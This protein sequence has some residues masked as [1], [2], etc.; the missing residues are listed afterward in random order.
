MAQTDII[1]ILQWWFMLFCGGLTVLPIMSLIFPSFVD[2][3]Y[4]FAKI[5]GVVLIS[6]LVFVFGTIRIAPFTPLTIYAIAVSVT[7]IS[8]IVSSRTRSFK[9]LEF[10]QRWMIFL[11]EEVLFLAALWFWAYVRSFNPDIYGLEKYMDFGF[12]NSILRTAYFPPRDMWFTP[13]SINYYYFGHLITAV[14]TKASQI[15]SYITFNLM[16]ATIFSFCFSQIYSL[17]ATLWRHAFPQN[18]TDT[19]S[20]KKKFPGAKSIVSTG[21]LAGALVSL[22]GNLHV[23]YALFSPYSNDKPQPLWELKFLPATFPNSYWYP[24]ATRFIFN[25]IHEFPIYS[26]VVSD[27]HGHVLDIP[28]VLLTISL[29]YS[30]FVRNKNL[31]LKGQIRLWYIIGIGFVIAVMYMTNAWDGLIYLL[32]A[33]L[34]LLSL[35]WQRVHLH[36]HTHTSNNPIL[37]ILPLKHRIRQKLHLFLLKHWLIDLII[38]LFVYLFIIGISFAA[39]SLPFSHFFSPS[40][41]VKGI[42]V[43]CSPKFLTDRGHFGPFLFEVDHCQKSPWWQLLTLYGFFYILVVMFVIFL[44]KK[45][46]QT[47]SDTFV[48][49]L[50]VLSTL[51]IIIPEFLYMKDIYPAHYRANTM[52]K[53]VF[54]AFMMLSLSCG[55]IIMRTTT[56]LRQK[57][58]NVGYIAIFAGYA[59]FITLLLT[60]VFTYPVLATKSYYN[61]LQTSQGLN[62]ITYLQKRYPTD[63]AGIQWLNKEV[64]GQPVILEAQGDSYT[65]YARVSA[66]TGLPTVL[67][68]T[69]HEWLW[70]GTYDIPAPRITEVQIMYETKSIADAEN[71]LRKYHVQYVFIGDMERQKYPTLSEDK[72]NQIGKKVFEMGNTRIYRLN[73]K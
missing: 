61:S 50:I 70:R 51:L 5:I 4:A 7:C 44:H 62:G 22:S 73:I 55:Y 1:Y 19:Q 64:I 36:K 35:E 2:R 17:A 54:Q 18:S 24:N 41:I 8:I 46:N 21:I 34:V 14:L 59:L 30:F 37:R 42:G 9:L 47:T 69:V 13:Y 6:Y 33:A 67:G 60:L 68:W 26:W 48:T 3:G 39:F 16:M 43:L 65:D 53:L 40:A 27:L 72:F 66:N 63:F 38:G 25:T 11:F 56:A 12:V 29:I 31:A 57:A 28:I 32:L 58:K 49:I 10:K 15:P 45:K 20:Q 23:L 52:F 71:L